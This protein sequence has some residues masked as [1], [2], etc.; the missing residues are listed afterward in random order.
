MSTAPRKRLRDVS[1]GAPTIVN[2]DGETVEALTVARSKLRLPELR[3]VIK[4]GQTDSLYDL[5][6]TD[7]TLI[8]VG[9]INAIK[10]P[11]QLEDRLAD[12][13]GSFP[14]YYKPSEFRAVANAL[15]AV[16]ELEDDGITP[17][18]LTCG[19][20][21]GYLADRLGTPVDLT[22][23]AERQRV[24]TDRSPFH[25]TDGRLYVPLEGL[26]GFVHYA[27]VVLRQRTGSKDMSARLARLGFRREEVAGPRPDRKRASFHVSPVGFDPEDQA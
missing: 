3:R 5:E 9:G 22:S 19:W 14:P 2:A 1:A 26:S 24:A 20:L 13:L 25:D 23:P 18:N 27:A 21:T 15:L 6:L 16:A 10:D 12:A 11:R 17:G 4:R 8:E 7:G